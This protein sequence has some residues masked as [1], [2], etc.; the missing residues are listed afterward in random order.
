MA[1]R[2]L[3]GTL[4]IRVIVD[5]DQSEE[6]S[7]KFIDFLED[8]QMRVVECSPDYLDRFDADRRKFHITAIPLNTINNLN[9]GA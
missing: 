7:K 3:P 1:G 2:V 4:Q 9:P 8:Q 6:I 5:S